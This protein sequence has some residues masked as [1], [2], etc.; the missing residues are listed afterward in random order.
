MPTFIVHGTRSCN[1]CKIKYRM[2]AA[3]E[4]GR[5]VNRA[6]IGYKNV[7]SNGSKSI[8]IDREREPLIKKAFELVASGSYS[9]DAVLRTVT[10]LGLRTPNGL[11]L[12]KQSFS[13][14]LK[15]PIYAGWVCFPSS[16]LMCKGNHEAIVSE[17]L[18]NTVQDVLTGKRAPVPKQKQH[19]D[20]P[21]RGFVRCFK[22][23]KPLTAAAPH[24][25]SKQYPRYW[26]WQKGCNAVSVSKEILESQFVGLLDMMQ[27][28]AELIARLPQISAANWELRKKR[29][30]DDR[31]TLQMRLNEQNALNRRA[32]E[33]KLVGDL[34]PEDFTAFKA[35][36]TSRIAEIEGQIKGL[37]SELSTMNELLAQAHIEVV[38][39]AETW[40]KAGVNEK[41][42]LQFAVFPDG[43]LWSP[44]VH[45][46]EPGNTTLMLAL[47]ELWTD[48]EKNH[49][50]VQD[51]C[52][53][54]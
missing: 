5:F 26:C 8:V 46:F 49:K 50:S 7:Q 39:L 3:V 18:F 48:L 23:R 19:P 10:A 20:F 22:C 16:N 28:T 1:S 41:Q 38:N 43:L 33:A 21:L 51:G 11:V 31:R 34:S 9:S 25:R 6:P 24:G 17:E 27:P 32:I 53:G 2:R 54:I 30:A 37:D 12:P 47:E 13:K 44:D 14:M 4:Q 40:K 36:V 35:E 42:E 15:N 52:W 45:Y 29:V